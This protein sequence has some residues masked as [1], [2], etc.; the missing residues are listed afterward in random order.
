M[1]ARSALRRASSSTD[2]AVEW[3]V[4]AAS[5]PGFGLGCPHLARTS[6]DK[7]HRPSWTSI[8]ETP[9]QPA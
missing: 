3:M 4:N 2:A 9:G 8:G 6:I 7:C 5:E 1:Y